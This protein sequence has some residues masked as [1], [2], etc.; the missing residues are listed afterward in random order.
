MSSHLSVW[1][2]NKLLITRPD[3]DMCKKQEFGSN[4]MKKPAIP[5]PNTIDTNHPIILP[6]FIAQIPINVNVIDINRKIADANFF[7]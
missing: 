7:G 5:N 6:S 1:L 3:S 2:L 4:I